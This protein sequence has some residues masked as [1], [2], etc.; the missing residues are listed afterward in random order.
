MK[1][2]TKQIASIMLQCIVAIAMLWLS[3]YIVGF[4]QVLFPAG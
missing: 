1:Q 2:V 3:L 4:L